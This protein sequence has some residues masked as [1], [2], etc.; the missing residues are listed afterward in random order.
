[1]T[2]RVNAM[3]AITAALDDAGWCYAY[4]ED[5]P[6]GGMTI[7]WLKGNRRLAVHF[8]LYGSLGSKRLCD[9]YGTGEPINWGVASATLFQVNE[10]GDGWTP[11]TPFTGKDKR[12]QLVRFARESAAEPAST[13]ATGSTGDTAP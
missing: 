1:M 7:T 10:A 9:F 13:T 8:K 11:G 2:G 5:Y 4:N 12:G 6:R 3:D